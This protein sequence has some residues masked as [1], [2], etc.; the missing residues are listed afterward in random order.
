MLSLL[1]L[2]LA[3][4]GCARP[5]PYIE[6]VLDTDLPQSVPLKIAIR[7]V[8]ID[9]VSAPRTDGGSDAPTDASD[10]R[11]DSA[12]DARADAGLDAAM[13][14]RVMDAAVD[15]RSDAGTDGRS[16]ASMDARDGAVDSGAISLVIDPSVSRQEYQRTND[17]G[18]SL[19]ASLVFT[20]DPPYEDRVLVE[21]RAESSSAPGFVAYSW[22]QHAVVRPS[23]DG[24]TIVR[25]VL[26]YHCAFPVMGCGSSGATRCNTDAW[27][28]ERGLTCGEDG[29][30]IDPSAVS[31]ASA[32]TRRPSADAC[33]P[34]RCDP[35][36]PPCPSGTTCGPS[37]AC[38][39]SA[40]RGCIDNDGDGYG[41]GSVCLGRDCDDARRDVS[42]ASA[43]LCDRIDN[44]CNGM[45]DEQGICGPFANSTCPVAT[46]I[47]LMAQRND[48]RLIDTAQGSAEL[49]PRCRFAGSTAGAGKEL[50]YS[51]TWPANEELDA[52]LER[53]GSSGDPV[54]LVFDRCPDAMAQPLACNDDSDDPLRYSSRV[55]IRPSTTSTAPRTLYFAADSYGES[56][57]GPMRLNVT[58]RPAAP[59]ASCAAPYD[60]GIGGAIY[61]L[62]GGRDGTTLSCTGRARVPDET[63]SMTLPADS[64][65]Y[66]RA[67]QPTAGTPLF[68]GAG[69]ACG[70]VVPD[71]CVRSDGPSPELIVEG[72]ST[73]VFTIE[74]GAAGTPYVLSL[75]TSPAG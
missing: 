22:T 24:P 38:V 62:F 60:V 11:T 50:W 44:D 23:A 20:V 15:A 25:M 17:G 53:V 21:V 67:A 39:R 40:S 13:D 57:S 18:I 75:A 8:R 55:V 65:L 32:P 19:P 73:T 71:R 28:R 61:G 36:C 16:D 72:G 51:V 31:T 4:A 29:V 10:A 66:V 64:S 45:V 6:L 52:R 27:C 12:M 68:L 43:E 47:S 33:A 48:A 70:M 59:A 41:E 3:L 37:N 5:R 26:S 58:R 34:G 74:G 35:W 49:G 2:G 46:P 14:A 54:L 42:P 30:C 69:P 7:V 9:R 1:A 63:F 56:S